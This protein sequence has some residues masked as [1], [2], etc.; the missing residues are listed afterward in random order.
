MPR[1]LYTT[2]VDGFDAAQKEYKFVNQFANEE[3]QDHEF[4]RRRVRSNYALSTITDDEM[5]TY[6]SLL[7]TDD[8][9]EFLL[10]PN[11]HTDDIGNIHGFRYST[12][13]TSDISVLPMTQQ[14][15]HGIS[16]SECHDQSQSMHKHAI[17]LLSDPDA[18]HSK[19]RELMNYFSEQHKYM[20]TASFDCIPVN[21]DANY[22]PHVYNPNTSKQ[23]SQTTQSQQHM[24]EGRDCKQWAYDVPSFVGIYHA[25]VRGKDANVREH[26]LFLLCGGGCRKACDQ[27]SNMITDIAGL[28]TV[29]E[30]LVSDES[31]WLR[32]VCQRNRCGIISKMANIFGLK[33]Q[34]T[35]DSNNYDCSATMATPITDTLT[36]DIQKLQN[37][38]IAVYND[39][40]DTTNVQNGIIHKMHAAEGVW[41]FQG[42]T[43]T[44]S[45]LRTSFGGM[46]GNQGTCGTFPVCT[47]QV[48]NDTTSSRCIYKERNVVSIKETNN[49]MW[50]DMKGNIIDNPV[51]DSNYV[52]CDEKYLKHLESMQWNRDNQ[53]IEF[54]PIIVAAMIPT[55]LSTG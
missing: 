12:S 27:Y 6:L 54:I 55:K 52:R 15:F 5:Q 29:E 36:H 43:R 38:H 1:G 40:C 44:T 42:A 39:C 46:F 2:Q 17:R 18:C 31:W 13:S 4:T 47:F 23:S 10:M 34:C 3:E 11:H 53:V 28:A 51:L 30:L 7:H 48:P 35:L 14:M 26:K 19:M 41:M 20:D 22:E 16:C 50:F 37:G 25:Y 21:T 33:I 24:S 8:S 32:R 49:V 9:G 45:S